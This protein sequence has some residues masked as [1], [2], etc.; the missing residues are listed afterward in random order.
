M[1]NT[2]PSA[3]KVN[4]DVKTNPEEQ[5]FNLRENFEIWTLDDNERIAHDKMA[6]AAGHYSN[7]SFYIIEVKSS[8][9]GYAIKQLYTTSKYII[10]KGF[11][12]EKVAIIL[13]KN[14]W[15]Y[16]SH[17][18]RIDKNG[19]LFIREKHNNEKLYIKHKGKTIIK[20]IKAF[21]VDFKKYYVE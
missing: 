18:Y 12:I 1:L 20:D 14:K 19:L 10:Q 15:K 16:R 11:S 2:E 7:C 13:D 21:L 17:R 9:V 6:D 3:P 5:I 8:D 4:L